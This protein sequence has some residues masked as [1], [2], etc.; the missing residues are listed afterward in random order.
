MTFDYAEQSNAYWRDP[1]NAGRQSYPDADALAEEILLSCAGGRVLD[2]GAGSGSLVQAFL[3]LGID[4]YGIDISDV[5]VAQARPVAPQRFQQGSV[6]DLPFADGSFDTVVACNLLE[7]LAPEDVARALAEIRRVTRRAVFLRIATSAA[8]P[9]ASHRTMQVRSWWE[10][11][12]FEAG[13][14][15]HPAYYQVNDYE[16]LQH[17]AAYA[18]I[19][20]ERI[21]DAA[22]HHYPI[23]TLVAESGPQRDMLRETGPASDAGLARYQWAA[24]YIRPGDAVLDA[25]CGM[26]SGSYLLQVGSVARSTLGIDANE[27][28]HGYALDNFAAIEP[29]LEFRCG[30]LPQALV[31][32]PDHSIDVVIAFDALERIHE[33]AATLTEFHR[34]LTPGGRLIASVPNDWSGEGGENPYPGHVQVY[35]LERLCGELEQHF[36]LEELAAQTANQYRM[37]AGH[38]SW[39]AAGRS[40]RQVPL[41]VRRD[42]SAPPAQWWLAVAMRSPLEGGA[43]PYRE[44][45]YPTFA[46]DDWNVTAFA[47]DYQNPWLVRGM[48]DIGHRLRNGAALEQLTA[49]VAREA[50]AGS[51]DA[52]AALC[53]Q[54]YRLLEQRSVAAERVAAMEQRIEYYLQAGAKT[55]HALRWDLSL[56]FVLGRLWLEHGD[57]ARARAALERCAAIDPMRFSPLLC[58]RV[59]EARLILGNLAIAQHDRMA[60]VEQWRAGIRLAQRAVGGDWSSALGDLDHP[61][62]F[63]LPELAS[64]LEYASACA[65]ALAHADEVESKQW[66]WLHPR[67]DRLS[68]ARKTAKALQHAQLGLQALQT[69]LQNYARQ[70]DTFVQQLEHSAAERAGL[71]VSAKNY[72]DELSAY[73]IQSEAYASRLAAVEAHALQKEHELTQRDQQAQ[74][75]TQ[76]LMSTQAQ[77]AQAGIQQDELN[78]YRLQAQQM[79]AQI[80]AQ[81][82]E[83]ASYES[84]AQSM[85][86]QITAQEDELGRY[87]LQAQQL[88]EQIIGQQNELGKYESQAQRMVGEIT[89][90]ENELGGYRSQAQQMAQQISAQQEQLD[91]DR[92]HMQQMAEKINNQRDEIDSYRLQTQ[93]MAEK[94]TMQQNELSSAQL[95]SSHLTAQLASMRDALQL[96]RDQEARSAATAAQLTQLIAQRELELQ[97]MLQSASWRVTRPLRYISASLKGRPQ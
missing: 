63:G 6:L 74:D 26:G 22:A 7:C 44:T 86:G 64:I 20:L 60:A 14:R 35:T 17:E 78:S 21:P 8:P 65:F 40:M 51:A 48:V 34:I 30:T 69:E 73:R 77:L 97:R 39:H 49:Q 92:L 42:G 24:R 38:G 27:Y 56:L 33:N 36:V 15:K 70:A 50:P 18:S 72:A 5:V 66:W 80:T 76:Q 59:V 55:P 43:V 28:A 79:M 89:S 10:Q 41:A 57:F 53:V 67:R 93:Q 4:A 75:L 11:R 81:Q 95:Q 88:A 61:A 31:L 46:S 62:E 13:M 94:I 58:N 47:R 12:A 68:Q 71:L 84:Q 1:Q 96:S 19:L 54:A 25:S 29:G 37:G 32:I 23:D 91:S 9:D 90:K 82:E 85:A 52:G 2:I 83:L 45:A 16:A 3:R 87:R